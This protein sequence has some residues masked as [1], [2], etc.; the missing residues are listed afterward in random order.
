M[1]ANIFSKTFWLKL[2]SIKDNLFQWISPDGLNPGCFVVEL[3][4]KF[5]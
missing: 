5:S 1:V 4:R 3:L 2:I